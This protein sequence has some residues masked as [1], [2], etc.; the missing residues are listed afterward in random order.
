[1]N[2]DKARPPV[3]DDDIIAEEMKKFVQSVV[4]IQ[5]A[6]RRSADVVLP[7]KDIELVG[8]KIRCFKLFEKYMRVGSEFEINVSWGE[9]QTWPV[10]SR[11]L[12]RTCTCICCCQIVINRPFGST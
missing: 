5:T 4:S 12:L 1:M 3:F 10:A 2:R 7:C 6:H 11:H 8:F 9:R